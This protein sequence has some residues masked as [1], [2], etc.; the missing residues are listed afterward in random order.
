VDLAL[1]FRRPD[2]RPPEPE[3]VGDSESWEGTLESAIDSGGDEIGV[4]GGGCKEGFGIAGGEDGVGGGGRSGGG[5]TGALIAGAVGA[6][7]CGWLASWVGGGAA[8]G[9]AGREGMGT[10]SPGFQVWG[11]R[12]I[13]GS[14]R[15]R[16]ACPQAR[17]SRVPMDSSPR[18][19]KER[20]PPPMEPVLSS[21]AHTK[22]DA[23]QLEQTGAT[24]SPSCK[25][26][27]PFRK[28]LAFLP[29]RPDP[30]P[31]GCAIEM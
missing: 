20:A 4:V 10:N 16:S 22:S 30:V 17:Q 6:A 28:R 18:A 24:R 14:F 25:V 2:F 19:R 3:S 26:R 7:T 5:A 11:I 9:A 12:R 8:G 13:E 27:P 21:F 23:P 31:S 15:N 29:E 1:D